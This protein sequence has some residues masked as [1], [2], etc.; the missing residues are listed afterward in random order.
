MDKHGQRRENMQIILL[1]SLPLSECL[2]TAGRPI[3]GMHRG[4]KRTE[5]VNSQP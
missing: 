4:Q 3:T 2:T 1:I 5:D